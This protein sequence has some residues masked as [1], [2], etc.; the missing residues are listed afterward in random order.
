MLVAS[1]I[2]KHGKFL[3]S[4]WRAAL[5]GASIYLTLTGFFFQMVSTCIGDWQAP[6]CEPLE[7]RDWVASVTGGPSS[8]QERGLLFESSV[9]LQ[10]VIYKGLYGDVNGFS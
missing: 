3:S 6:F 8:L 10:T 4:G 5:R 1:G 9:V 7:D 2:I